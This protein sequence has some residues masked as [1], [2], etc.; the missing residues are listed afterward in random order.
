M[1]S[2][3]GRFDALVNSLILNLLAHGMNVEEIMDEY[4]L[5]KDQVRNALLFNSPLS[6]QFGK[7]K[8][9]NYS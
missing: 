4:D 9:H 6:G 5:T 1:Y 7:L 3:T 2:L 8:G